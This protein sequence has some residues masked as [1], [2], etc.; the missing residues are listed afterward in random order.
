MSGAPIRLAAAMAMSAMAYACAT[1]PE[2]GDSRAIEAAIA[3]IVRG[4][5]IAKGVPGISIVVLDPGSGIDYVAG[6]GVASTRGGQAVTGDTEFQLGSVSKVLTATMAVRLASRGIVDLGS[7]ITDSLPGLRW[8]SRFPADRE[9]TFVDVA[10]HHSGL[11]NDDFRAFFSYE[12]AEPDLVGMMSDRWTLYPVGTAYS[13]SNIGVALEGLA[14]AAA[15]GKEFAP[16]ADEEAFGPLGMPSSTFSDEPVH[17]ERAAAAH[18]GRTPRKHLHSMTRPA[19]GAWSSAR[20]M[21]RFLAMVLGNGSLDGAEYLAPE[22]IES[23]LEPKNEGNPFDRDLLLGLGWFRSG[24]DLYAR[25]PLRYGGRY[26]WHD[27]DTVYQK[28]SML[29]LPDEGIGIAVLANS[30]NAAGAV[31]RIAVRV[32]NLL[33]AVNGRL[34]GPSPGFGWKRPGTQAQGDAQ[35]IGAALGDYATEYMGI[36]R[37]SN[38]PFGPEIRLG[39]ATLGLREVADGCF[40]PTFLGMAMPLFS[41]ESIRFERID[42]ANAMFIRSGGRTFLL[43]IRI[44][45]AKL[46]RSWLDRV[47]EYVPEY[48][49]GVYPFISRIGLRAED[50]YLRVEVEPFEMGGVVLEYALAPASDSIAIVQGIGRYLGETIEA[51]VEGQ[52]ARFSFGGIGFSRKP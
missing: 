10:T 22:W 42:G 51:S 19:G 18:L 52:D 16:L 37:V 9:P 4:E 31:T 14:L 15:A 13:Y 28:A 24:I 32:A 17:P 27:G 30:S 25:E 26:A 35:P 48:P 45:P 49:E 50:G 6:F 3:D 46:E 12:P 43:G 38:G 20:D 1:V 41:D 36:V 21:R 40:A 47:G 39:G 33:L 2:R 34:E 11:P 8:K 5:G 29:V 44:E 7:P 23:M